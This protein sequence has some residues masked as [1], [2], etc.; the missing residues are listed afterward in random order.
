MLTF[1]C[2]RHYNYDTLNQFPQS[3]GLVLL[4]FAGEETKAQ[5]GQVIAQ[6]NTAHK[7]PERP[8]IEGKADCRTLERMLKLLLACGDFLG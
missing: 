4:L 3:Q 2:A 8:Q 1:H 5:R 7:D 6:S